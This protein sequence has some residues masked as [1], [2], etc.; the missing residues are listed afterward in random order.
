MLSAEVFE[1]FESAIRERESRGEKVESNLVGINKADIIESDVKNRTAY[2]TVKFVSELISVTRDA[3]GEV[4]EGDPKKVREVTDIWTFARDISSQE[5]ELEACRDRIRRTEPIP[6]LPRSTAP[7]PVHCCLAQSLSPSRSI[8]CC[9]KCA[10]K[11]AGISFAPVSFAEIEGWDA[12]DQAAA[13]QTLLRSCGRIKR[14]SA[15]VEACAAAKALAAKGAVSREAARSFFEA[16]YTPHRVVGASKPGL[17]TGYY[18]PEIDGARVK[19]DKFPV[20]PISGLTI[21][22]R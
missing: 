21:S 9:G 11:S 2:V 15:S 7:S 5:S 20:P 18:E 6:A 8:F 14:D 10:W 17:V 12:D 16:N 22:Y 3:E 13:F 1:G 4:V 19:S